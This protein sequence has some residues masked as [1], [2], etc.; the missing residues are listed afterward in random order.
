LGAVLILGF[1]AV[2]LVGFLGWRRRMRD[3]LPASDRRQVA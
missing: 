3:G 1:T 2:G